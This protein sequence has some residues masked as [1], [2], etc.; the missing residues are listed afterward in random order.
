VSLVGQPRL[1]CA[2]SASI[3]GAQG[4][5]GS[6]ELAAYRANRHTPFANA[7]ESPQ[8]AIARR[9]KNDTFAE[10]VVG[11]PFAGLKLSL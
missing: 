8:V 9:V 3:D 2:I 7:E 4:A 6:S 1:A 5:L 10:F 11:D